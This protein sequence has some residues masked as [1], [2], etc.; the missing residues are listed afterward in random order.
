MEKSADYNRFLRAIGALG[1]AYRT[2]T[3]SDLFAVYWLALA[4]IAIQDVEHACTR[5]LR[6]CKF[7]PSVAELRE[8]SGIGKPA[9]QAIVAWVA[10]EKAV[11]V[12]GGYK[13]VCFDDP[14]LNATIASLGGW[15]Y[16]CE[17][18][19]DEFDKWLRK[20]FERLYSSLMRSGIGQ[21]SHL[22]GLHERENNTN[23]QRTEPPVMITTGLKRDAIEHHPDRN[24][25]KRI[26]GAL[27]VA[28]TLCSL[29]DA[30]IVR[31]WRELYQA[32]VLQEY[33]RTQLQRWNW[34]TQAVGRGG[35]QIAPLASGGGWIGRRNVRVASAM[36][37]R[38]AAPEA[39]KA[40][41]DLRLARRKVRRRRITCVA[42]I[43]QAAG[44]IVG[45]ATP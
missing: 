12:H 41:M 28:L 26:M 40:S 33:E 3:D 7:F 43:A 17:L 18:G 11:R 34:E 14:T 1:V 13:S 45:A 6:E 8:L 9:D 38:Y 39:A 36:Q 25:T 30:Q 2:D 37:V 23:G 42:E 35:A 24:P 19:V 20:D 5:A 44:E 29:T 21:T 32:E 15:A 16:V 27:I 10:F 22:I 31:R 4:D